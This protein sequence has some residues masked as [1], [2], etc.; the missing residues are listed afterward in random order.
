MTIIAA[1]DIVLGPLLTLV[2]Y[3]ITKTKWHL[4]RDIGVIT[5]L[6]LSCL[7]AG[8]LIVN[9]AK[10]IAV[11]HVYDTFHVISKPD[12]NSRGIDPSP[13]TEFTGSYP[14]IL[15]TATETNPIAFLTKSTLDKLNKKIPLQWR[16]SAYR[17]IPQNAEEIN[18]I[19][20]SSKAA[21]REC[22]TQNITSRYTSGTVCFNPNNLIFTDFKEGQSIP[23]LNKAEIKVQTAP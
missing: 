5:A 15:Y 8:T 14:K 21:S 6:Q 9:Q 16:L 23:L 1:V 20:Q 17:A 10:P 12:F 18:R 4:V 3:D 11:V 19:L 2:V 22:I 13:L 7:V